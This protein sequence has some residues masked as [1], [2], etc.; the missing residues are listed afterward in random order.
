MRALRA[1]GLSLRAVADALAVEGIVR[2]DSRR[3]EA[4]GYD[5]PVKYFFTVTNH[6]RVGGRAR[7]SPCA[8]YADIGITRIMPTSGLCQPSPAISLGKR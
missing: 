3:R 1:E 6:A 7:F 4:M 8:A 2:V 5:E